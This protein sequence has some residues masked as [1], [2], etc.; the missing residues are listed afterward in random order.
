M[1]TNNLKE[2]IVHL[3]LHIYTFQKGKELKLTFSFSFFCQAFIDW[4]T[5]TIYS[6]HDSDLKCIKTNMHNRTCN[7]NHVTQR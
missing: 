2:K 1:H 4:D 7:D 5:N 6:I 3:E